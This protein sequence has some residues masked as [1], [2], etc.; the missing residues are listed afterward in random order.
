MPTEHTF[1]VGDIC[2]L[3]TEALRIRN[4]NNDYTNWISGTVQ[5]IGSEVFS[6]IKYWRVTALSNIGFRVSQETNFQTQ[7]IKPE[8][9]I[10]QKQKEPKGFKAFQQR[11]KTHA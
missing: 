3:N 10:L 6:A 5:I 4:L 7:H 2:E 1:Q 11:L 8:H 9:L